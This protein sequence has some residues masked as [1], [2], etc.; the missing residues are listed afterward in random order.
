MDGNRAGVGLWGHLTSLA[1]PLLYGHMS[2]GSRGTHGYPSGCHVR[3]WEAKHLKQGLCRH[4]NILSK[5]CLQF[6]APRASAFTKLPAPPEWR[7]EHLGDLGC[8]KRVQGRR[9]GGFLPIPGS[10]SLPAPAPKLPQLP[11]LVP[12]FP[13]VPTEKEGLYGGSVFTKGAQ[14]AAKPNR[15]PQLQT[16]EGGPPAQG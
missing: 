3:R 12:G 7:P 9:A 8:H 6:S 1:S 5:H 2:L 14:E 11:S 15:S 10:S 16:K 4:W 13:P